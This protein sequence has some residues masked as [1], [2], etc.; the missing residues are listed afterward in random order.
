MHLPNRNI[1]RNS[2]VCTPAGAISAAAASA[3]A[4]I[5]ASATTPADSDLTGA[6]TEAVGTANDQL[7]PDTP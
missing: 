2:G 1:Y 3:G 4:G 5:A 6:I 7:D